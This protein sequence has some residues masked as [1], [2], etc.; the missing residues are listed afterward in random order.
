[1]KIQLEKIEGGITAIPGLQAAGVSCGIKK[2][3]SDD[4]ALVYCLHPA[5][6]AGVF[7]TN[8]FKAPP[9]LV[10]EKHLA[11]PVRALVVNSGNA[12]ACRIGV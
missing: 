4:L 6:C 3:G 10:T 1:M 11:N 9:L 7:T 12:N 2:D 5:A 8:K